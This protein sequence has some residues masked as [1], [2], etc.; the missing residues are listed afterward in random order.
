VNQI[1]GILKALSSGA[2]VILQNERIGRCLESALSV[3]SQPLGSEIAAE[4]RCIDRRCDKRNDI[5]S[6]T[7]FAR[8]K[9]ARVGALCI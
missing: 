6:V 3:L 8:T 9:R 5:T 2:Q 1:I 4:M 7:K